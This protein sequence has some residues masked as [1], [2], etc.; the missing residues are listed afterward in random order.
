LFDKSVHVI[1]PFP[2]T[3]AL[4][5]YRGLDPHLA[6]P[7]VGIEL[8]VDRFENKYVC[9]TYIKEADTKTIKKD[10]KDRATERGYRLA[11]TRVDRSCD[12]DIK[13]L[14]DRNVFKELSTGENA[15]PAMQ[16][17]EKFVGSIHAGVDLIKQDLA[18]DKITGK[19]KLFIFNT[20]ENKTIINAMRT[21]EREQHANEDEKGV[22]DKIKEGK[23]DTHAALRYI[24]QK[25]TPWLPPVE[26][27]PEQS[28]VN[29]AVNY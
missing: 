25:R 28:P 13:V 8:A 9:G 5:V 19:P 14:N 26:A 3:Q 1:E 21:L 2:I 6:K 16:R 7:T 17:S 24:F 11:Q 22:K 27:V 10:L 29:E 4:V 12:W 15:I 23:H 20:K 18:V